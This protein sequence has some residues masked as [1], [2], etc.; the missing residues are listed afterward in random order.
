[1]VK[2]YL[3]IAIRNMLSQKAYSLINIL[4]L[5]VGMAACILI[6]LFVNDEL[7]YDKY[8]ENSERI[9]R[10]SRAWKNIDGATSLHLGQ[11]APPFAPLLKSDFE[12]IV[13]NAVRFLR[14]GPLITFE[15]TKIEEEKFFFADPDVFEVF[16]W[17]LT[18]G[19]PATALKEP[20]S[21]VITQ[22]TAE[23]YFGT[24]NPMG[25]V[26][27]YNNEMDMKVTGV[28]EDVPYNS[29]FTVDFLCS[30]QTVEDFFGVENLMNNWG[31]N[32]YGT[33]LLLPEGYNYMD[34]QE[35]LGGFLNKHLQTGSRG[36]KPEEYNELTLWPITDIHLHSHL[37]SE[38]E[39]NGD[40]AYI[41][42]FTAIAFLI[43]IIACINFMNL[44][45]A[46][47]VKRAKEVGLRKVMG[48]NK[49]MLIR[50]FL[51]ESILF[52]VISL[53]LAIVI[54]S[55]LLPWFNDFVQKN[56]SI[57]LAG[58]LFIISLFTG[59]T[60]LVG[61]IAGSYPA[62][63]LSRFQ[64]A[65]ILKGQNKRNR[66][67]FNLRSGLV[68]VQFC[69][70]M[71][72]IISVGVIQDQLKYMRAKPLGFNKDNLLVL[73]I[74]DEIYNQYESVR[75]RLLQQPGINDVSITSRVPS[76]RLLDSQGATAEVDGDMKAI[77]FR[78][79]DVHIDHA[80]LASLEVPITAGRDFDINRASDST[81]AFILNESAV[82]AI[83]WDSNDEALG[84]AFDYGDRKGKVIG[85]VK[86]FH[87]ES[88]HQEIAPIVFLISSGRSRSMA[89][90]INPVHKEKTMSYLKE[91]WSY[92]RPGFPFT[93]YWINEKYSEQYTNEDRLASLVTCFSA[94]AIIIASLG[95]FGLASF[96]TEQRFKEIGVRKVMG[97]TVSQILMLLT[98]GFTYLVCISFLIA[99]VLT[100]YV[101]ESWLQN[102]AY[103]TTISPWPFFWGG[104]LAILIAWLTVGY[105]SIKAAS[106]NPIEALRHDE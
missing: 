3:K 91:Q 28:M 86:D 32:N 46:R 67:G 43:L 37:D 13:L 72:L 16:S 22:S 39:A 89:L 74:S 95:L 36:R 70:S 76:G 98:K 45:T 64:P 53:V 56:L 4:G 25:K 23:K 90:R 18:M 52:A 41:Y 103:Q 40:I 7:S 96:T 47:S 79:A 42:T 49:G 15:E 19:D 50:Q 83:G 93:H 73:P 9:V 77:Q 69:I 31:S 44:S 35:Q 57:S 14:D 102:F 24:A 54:V 100:W 80:F 82:K 84:K 71:V 75:S 20:N 2:N 66:N 1:M 65:N 21:L 104:A 51:T 101:M 92:L 6:L 106:S 85:I 29:H 30:F 5:S 55:A 88:L 61:V 63:F 38:I 81:E 105:Q 26:L 60:L 34:L 48:A 59:I 99:C 97:A 78:I 11:V 17:K 58:N 10:V 8:H 33:Y 12:G 27:N 68:V 87:F 62:L 94:L